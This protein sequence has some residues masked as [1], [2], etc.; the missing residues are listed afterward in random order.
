[1]SGSWFRLDE[2]VRRMSGVQRQNLYNAARVWHGGIQKQL[3]GPRTGR[4]YPVPGTR[5]TYIASAPGEPPARRLGTLAASYRYRVAR[6]ER[7]R[8]V[9]ETGTPE[10][11]GLALEKGTENMEPREHV[12]PAFDENRKAILNE[13][14]RRFD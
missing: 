1:M 11:Y 13:L 3:K 2:F 8:L 7:S 14:T 12:K 5:R 6:D 10:E 9:G 4:E